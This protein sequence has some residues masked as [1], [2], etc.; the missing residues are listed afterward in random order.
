MG[1]KLYS[2]E[3]SPD[4]FM[5]YFSTK[6]QGILMKTCRKHEFQRHGQYLQDLREQGKGT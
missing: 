5:K 4:I 1:E 6:Q 2:S 3:V